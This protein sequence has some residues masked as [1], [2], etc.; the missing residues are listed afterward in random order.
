ML[1]KHVTVTF[2][3]VT[4]CCRVVIFGVQSPF[5]KNRFKEFTHVKTMKQTKVI[6]IFS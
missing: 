4:R 3:L 2:N 6:K 5:F 1:E